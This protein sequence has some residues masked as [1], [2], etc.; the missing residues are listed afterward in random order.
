MDKTNYREQYSRYSKY[1]VK[2]KD[3]LNQNPQLRESIEPLLSLITVS[4]ILVFALRPTVNTIS[5]LY[6][7]INSQKEI[8]SKL[9][10]KIQ[11]L[12]QARQAFAVSQERLVLLDQA[13]PLNPTPDLFLR[14]IEGLVATH[15]LTLNSLNFGETT[16]FGQP[17]KKDLPQKEANT[18]IEN[19][20]VLLS[21]SGNFNN[22][23]SFLKDLESL[24]QIVSIETFSL[25]TSSSQGEGAINL[26]ISAKLSS[27]IKK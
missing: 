24:R 26:A 2:L 8:I 27:F 25:G 13:L 12:M 6:S 21:V 22:V 9:E 16:L 15:A 11:N 23:N 14:Q 7:N 5:E 17:L 18:Q 4:F 1:F 19:A 10:T 20:K 3:A